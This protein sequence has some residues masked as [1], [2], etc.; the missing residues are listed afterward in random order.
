M[1]KKNAKI[2]RNF[3]VLSCIPGFGY[4]AYTYF[5]EEKK[6]HHP[7]GIPYRHQSPDFELI[8][9]FDL[10]VATTALMVYVLLI[11]LF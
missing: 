3:L 8:T 7:V 6:L 4:S 9:T 2:I 11:F 10:C 5:Q 1:K